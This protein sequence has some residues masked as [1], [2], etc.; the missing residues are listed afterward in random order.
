MLSALVLCVTGTVG[1][2]AVAYDSYI[3]EKETGKALRAPTAM[4]PE[5]CLNG[6][7]YAM[8]LFRNPE[9]AAVDGEG[10]VYILDSGNSR[11]VCLSPELELLWTL[12]RPEGNGSFTDA[13][14]LFVGNGMLYI[15]DTGHAR[16]LQYPLPQ[17]QEEAD[18][19][20]PLI[21]APKN[22]LVEN[23]TGFKPTKLVADSQGRLFI[24]TEGVYEGLVELASDGEF[25]AYV[26][27]NRVKM[28]LLDQIWRLFSTEAQWRASE[29]FVPVEFSNVCMDSEGFIFTTSRGTSG[30]EMPIRR[31]NLSGSDVLK[32][33]EDEVRLGDADLP[34]KAAATYF[35]DVAAGPYGM[36]AGLD[37]TRGRVFVYNADVR[38]LFE[39]GGSGS[40][41][42]TFQNPVALLWL[43]DGR[44]AV[45][46][47][48]TGNLTVFRPTAYGELV[49]STAY[50]EDIGDYTAS[51]EAYTRILTMNA[52][53]EIAYVGVGE[54]YYRQGNY[55]EAM[56]CYQLGN[57]TKSYS[58][59]FVKERQKTLSVVIPF[60]IAALLL[61]A[62]AAIVSAVVKKVRELRESVRKIRNMQKR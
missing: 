49:L 51:A 43:Q 48:L 42:G 38:L 27:A 11:V 21:L 13:R 24:V 52:N 41:N 33:A 58:K 12:T 26:G 16:V 17:S 1:A 22:L 14:G 5:L 40:Q 45:L 20:L 28:S 15:A 47:R 46:D 54:Q 39:F 57:D 60:V 55:K 37:R 53:S 18:A 9:D 59:A 25:L 10:R 35:G 6:N 3:Y 4:V 7:T 44:M 50:Y 30:D 36:F 23:D 32:N 56:R 29:K 19:A 62:L 34:S 31:L 8:S 61:A 2:R